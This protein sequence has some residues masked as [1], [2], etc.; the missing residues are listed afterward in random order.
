MLQVAE[1]EKLNYKNYAEKPIKASVISGYFYKEKTVKD[2][3]IRKVNKSLCWLLSVAILTTFVS[4]YFVMCQ[5]LTLNTLNRQITSLNDE[6]FD[7]QNKL[8]SMKSFSNVDSKMAQFKILQK[9]DNV[10]EVPVVN[11][12]KPVF[13][14]NIASVP[15][16]RLIGY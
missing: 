12:V 2:M 5:E 15:F 1:K 9:A 7:L 6:N 11:V 14:D 13:N 16:N 8:D 3:A 10:I 4:Y